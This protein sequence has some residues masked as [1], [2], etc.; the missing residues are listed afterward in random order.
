MERLLIH[1]RKEN[2][3]SDETVSNRNLALSAQYRND[4]PPLGSLRG[5]VLRF[6]EG[7]IG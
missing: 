7:I 6:T 4:K 2:L 1:L 3:I 5:M